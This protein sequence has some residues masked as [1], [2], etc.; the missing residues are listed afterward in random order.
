MILLD[1]NVLSALM[2]PVI[3]PAI[4]AWLVGQS[5]ATLCTAS[6]CEAEIRYGLARLPLGRR[7]NGLPAAF[8]RL[9]AEGFSGRILP[10]DRAAA[11][12]SATFRAE[13]ERMGQPVAFADAMI[14]ATAQ[15]HGAAVATRKVD[16]FAGCG[17]T[18]INLWQAPA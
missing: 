13:R 9:L 11:A 2:R 6:L 12:A 1:T 4:A 16:D 5:S 7:R 8:E 3:D 14:A 17:V 10:F 15:V 18:V